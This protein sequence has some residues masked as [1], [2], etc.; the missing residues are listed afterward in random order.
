LLGGILLGIVTPTE[1]AVVAI[2]Y[3]FIIGLFVYRELTIKKLLIIL[4]DTVETTVTVMMILAT[5]A[6]FA[7][8]LAN[9]GAPQAAA[10]LF[11]SLTSN[12]T[13]VLLIIMV[14]MLIVGMFMEAGAAMVI[15]IPVLLPIIDAV[16]ISRVHLGIVIVLALMIGLLTP[17]VGLVLFVLSRTLKV[18]VETVV[19]GVIPF[20]IPLVIIALLVTMIPGL[21][22]WIPSLFAK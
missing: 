10:R 16:G 14:I 11:L 5:S 4:I 15:L 8:I 20:L 17:P 3:S 22:L 13:L 7:W 12:P 1:G 18:S 2:I 9:E 21:S 19:K 6:I